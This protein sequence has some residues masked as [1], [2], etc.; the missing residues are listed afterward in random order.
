MASFSKIFAIALLLSASVAP[1][2]LQKP[3][4]VWRRS[5]RRVQVQLLAQPLPVG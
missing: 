5:R 2:P 4:V 3:E 1:K